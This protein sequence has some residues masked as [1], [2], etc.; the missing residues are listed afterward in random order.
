MPSRLVLRYFKDA[1]STMIEEL[2]LNYANFG[3]ESVASVESALAALVVAL[4]SLQQTHE[5]S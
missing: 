1:T 3:A 5:T 2:R 4:N